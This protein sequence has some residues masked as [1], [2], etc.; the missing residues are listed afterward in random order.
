MSE[1]KDKV[2]LVT[3]ST[4][5]LG[6]HLALKLA[7]DG[8]RVI[9]NGRDPEKLEKVADEFQALGYEAS[10]IRGDVSSPDDCRRIIDGCI[11]KFGRLDIL[12]NI[13][14]QKRCKKFIN[15]KI[16]RAYVIP[17]CASQ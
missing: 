17:T 8:A 12:N 2:A 1:I 7:S 10:G 4:A 3:G 15:G 11:E 9:L 16:I 6:K 13:I 5:G 14:F